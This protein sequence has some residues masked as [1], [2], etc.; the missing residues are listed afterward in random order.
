M[1]ETEHEATEP[2][3]EV[4]RFTALDGAFDDDEPV[5]VEDVDD[6]GDVE[7]VRLHG[8]SDFG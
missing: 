1:S 4:H 6:D 2:E 3:V 8:M 7:D 5:A